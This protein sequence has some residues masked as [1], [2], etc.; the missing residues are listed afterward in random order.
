MSPRVG[1]ALAIL[2]LVVG[3]SLVRAFVAVPVRVASASMEPTLGTGDVV[4]VSRTTPRIDDVQR[5]DLVVFDDPS[6][7]RRTIKRVIGLPGEAIVVL[8][9]VLHID[10]EPVK[11]SWV[12]PATVD[13]SFTRTF[14][15]PDDEVFLL[16][17]NRGNSVD[18]RDFGSL[19][20]AALEG[21]VVVKLLPLW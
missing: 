20:A 4:L 19:P 14:H 9:G 18:S 10:G 3:V 12:D 7:H 2:M 16:G 21:R 5:W 11:E 17:D 15:V 6:K 8:D 1:T 13:G